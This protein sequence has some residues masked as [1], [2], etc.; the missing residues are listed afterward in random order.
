ME[1]TDDLEWL[2]ENV[3]QTENMKLGNKKMWHF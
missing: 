3:W 1:P 2:R